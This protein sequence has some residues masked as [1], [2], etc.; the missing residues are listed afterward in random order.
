[1]DKN[2]F[3]LRADPSSDIQFD[4]AINDVPCR[5]AMEMEMQVHEKWYL[6]AD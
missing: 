6:G 3:A 2:N 4:R 1:M 5:E